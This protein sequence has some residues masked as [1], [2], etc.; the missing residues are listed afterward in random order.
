MEPVNRKN[1]GEVRRKS[2]GTQGNSGNQKARKKLVVKS[3][4]S[5]NKTTT[6]EKSSPVP[7]I[8]GVDQLDAPETGARP[9]AGPYYSDEIEALVEMA[10][11]ARGRAKQ[12]RIFIAPEGEGFTIYRRAAK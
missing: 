1:S 9:L 4:R 2:G 5:M 11:T 7:E 8:P 3:A 12:G 6:S 10:K